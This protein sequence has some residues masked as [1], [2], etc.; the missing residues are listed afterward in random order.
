MSTVTLSDIIWAGCHNRR[1][2]TKRVIWSCVRD[3]ACERE[4]RLWPTLLQIPLQ[5][6]VSTRVTSARTASCG[7]GYVWFPEQELALV[8]LTGTQRCIDKR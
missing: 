5:T 4:A 1:L 7:A 2:A 8:F 6:L 3:V